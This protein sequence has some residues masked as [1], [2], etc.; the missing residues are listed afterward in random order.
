MNRLVTVT[1]ISSMNS[2]RSGNPRYR[3]Y[4]AAGEEL[5]TEDDNAL[6]YHVT[7]DWVGRTFRFEVEGDQIVGFTQLSDQHAEPIKVL[8]SRSRRRNEP[9]PALAA[10]LLELHDR[11]SIS[12]D[13]WRSAKDFVHEELLAAFAEEMTL[14]E[15]ARKIDG[16]PYPNGV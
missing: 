15:A 6:V 4:G 14:E 13:R 11:T 9:G 7:Q 5:E 8:R 16:V 10:D 3:I 1:R 12:L 2:S